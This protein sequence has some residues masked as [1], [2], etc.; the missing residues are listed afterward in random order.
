MVLAQNTGNTF[1][2]PICLDDMEEANGL[3]LSC[4]DVMC[5]ECAGS[6][7]EHKLQAKPK[8]ETKPT[9]KAPLKLMYYV[10]SLAWPLELI[11][12]LS[13]PKPKPRTDPPTTP[14]DMHVPAQ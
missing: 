12:P 7:V 6:F 10:L 8:P 5:R 2:C 3:F 9:P 1:Q 14:K 4:G 11:H 13:Q